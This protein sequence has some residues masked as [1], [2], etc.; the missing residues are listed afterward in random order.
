MAVASASV[1]KRKRFAAV[2]VKTETRISENCAER[3]QPAEV[4]A[5]SEPIGFVHGEWSS[6]RAEKS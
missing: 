5:A 2:F 6:R 3:R 4:R 1:A